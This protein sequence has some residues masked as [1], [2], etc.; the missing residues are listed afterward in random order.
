[1]PTA[2][3][4]LAG[5]FPLA[6]TATVRLLIV[7]TIVVPVW[8]M[9]DDHG[10]RHSTM[11]VVRRVRPVDGP[12][13]RHRIFHVVR[14]ETGAASGHENCQTDQKTSHGSL[15]RGYS[16]RSAYVYKN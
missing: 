2:R 14:G 7:P 9:D 1:V 10:S 11:V 6:T 8:R 15:H 3:G 16:Q 12:V 5:H 13:D 4:A